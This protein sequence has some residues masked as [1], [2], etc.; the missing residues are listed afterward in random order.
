MSRQMKSFCTREL[1]SSLYT[2]YSDHSRYFKDKEARSGRRKEVQTD[3][4]SVE[5][6]DAPGADVDFAKYDDSN[7][8]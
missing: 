7:S 4:E 6:P 5:I 3:L 2:L 8:S 1:I